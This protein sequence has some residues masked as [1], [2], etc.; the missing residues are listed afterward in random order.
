MRYAVLLVV[1]VG[2][3]GIVWSIDALSADGPLKQLEVKA[4]NLD[5]D[6]NALWM[7]GCDVEDDFGNAALLSDDA[8][9]I[10]WT[11]WIPIPLVGGSGSVTLDVKMKGP[12]G[13]SRKSRTVTHADAMLAGYLDLKLGK[14]P[15]GKYELKI[16]VKKSRGTKARGKAQLYFQVV[17]VP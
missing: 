9:A 12:T 6:S 2:T 14:L 10:L 4:A 8:E 1:L 17:T 16:K 11:S 13:R 7:S 3:L 15:A 5:K